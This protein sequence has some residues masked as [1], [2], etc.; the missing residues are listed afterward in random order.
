[1]SR[2][3]NDYEQFREQMFAGLN[4]EKQWASINN[5]VKPNVK[6]KRHYL[7]PL[8]KEGYNPDKSLRISL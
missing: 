8:Q 5:P 2:L 4:L 3:K 7:K 6:P 1:M